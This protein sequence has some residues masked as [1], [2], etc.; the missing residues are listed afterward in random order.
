VPTSIA[1]ASHARAAVVLP[2]AVA[3]VRAHT[4]TTDTAALGRA[5]AIDADAHARPDAAVQR[6][7]GPTPPSWPH[8][9]NA[10]FGPMLST[11]TAPSRCLHVAAIT[12]VTPAT[13]YNSSPK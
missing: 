5:C 6:A 13:S 8:T 12:V 7:R 9:A 10:V 4:H 1:A 3:T 2:H 11:L